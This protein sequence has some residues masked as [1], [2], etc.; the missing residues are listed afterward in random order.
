MALDEYLGDREKIPDQIAELASIGGLLQILPQPEFVLRWCGVWVATGPWVFGVRS[1]GG[2]RGSQILDLLGEWTTL[3]DQMLPLLIS[4]F[5]TQLLPGLPIGCEALDEADERAMGILGGTATPGMGL[6]EHLSGHLEV[7]ER[8]TGRQAGLVLEQLE[9]SE[10]G[11]SL[12]EEQPL[13][14][15]HLRRPQI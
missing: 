9:D 7:V 10:I 8:M 13:V 15:G 12:D 6:S 14:F 3:S 11:P 5:I 1:V 4:T 2:E